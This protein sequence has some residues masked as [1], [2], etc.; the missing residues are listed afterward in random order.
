MIKSLADLLTSLQRGG[1]RRGLEGLGITLGTAGTLIFSFNTAVDVF[2]NNL[3]ALPLTVVQ[4]AG[5]IGLHIYFSLVI[6]AMATK[7]IQNSAKVFLQ[8]K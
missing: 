5:L 3:S 8:R 1:L 2:R 4:F 7:Y 6:G